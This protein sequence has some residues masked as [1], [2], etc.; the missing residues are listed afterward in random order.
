[1]GGELAAGRRLAEGGQAGQYL[2]ELQGRE[3]FRVHLVRDSA[4]LGRLTTLV[5]S[6][7]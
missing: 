5:P 6:R 4:V 1:M 7:R 3:G 2:I